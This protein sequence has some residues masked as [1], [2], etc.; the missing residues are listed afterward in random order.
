MSIVKKVKK[1][2]DNKWMFIY[3]RT[4]RVKDEVKQDAIIE[5]TIKLV[6]EIGFVSSSV[7]K[8]AKEANVSPATLY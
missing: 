5:A 4:M 6:N 3:F 8:I 7:S 2:L 1:L